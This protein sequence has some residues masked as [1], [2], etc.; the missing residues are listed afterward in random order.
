MKATDPERRNLAIHNTYARLRYRGCG[1]WIQTKTGK[2]FPM[3]GSFRSENVCIEDIAH[4]LSMQCRYGGHCRLFYSI[5]EHSVWV[6]RRVEELTRDLPD[7]RGILKSALMHDA[8]EAYVGDI[9]SPLKRF[10]GQPIA[11]LEDTAMLSIAHRYGLRDCYSSLIRQADLECLLAE[12]QQLFDPPPL[13]DW[14]SEVPFEPWAG[15]EVFGWHPPVAKKRFLHEA[16]QLG[17]RD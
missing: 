14:C 6:M 5:A 12:A 10:L 13:E 11:D 1:L 3:D 7:Q 8:G 16:E 9:A 17:I 4:S 2:R 15:L